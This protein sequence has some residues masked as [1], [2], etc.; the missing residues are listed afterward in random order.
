RDVEQRIQDRPVGDRV[1]AVPHPLCL[2]KRRRHAPG[3]E[4][5]AA[6]DDRGRNLAFGHEIIHSDA[7]LCAIALPEPANSRRQTLE[8]N[9]LSRQGEPTLEMRILWKQ[10]QRQRIGAIDVFGIARKGHPT[11]RPFAFAEQWPNVL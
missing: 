10:L 11:K 2:S 6:N 3:I 4:M 5:I 7:E 8:L 9:A 1:T